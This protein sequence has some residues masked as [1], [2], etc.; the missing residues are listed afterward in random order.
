MFHFGFGIYRAFGG[1]R[2][3]A[4]AGLVAALLLTLPVPSTKAHEG[5]D[6]GPSEAVAGQLAPRISARSETFEL[7]GI[8]RGERLVIY[9]DR[10]AIE[11]AGHHRRHRGDDRRRGRCG[12]RRVGRRGHLRADVAAIP[13]RGTDRAGV[14]DHRR[15]RRRFARWHA[16]RA[17]G[18]HGVGAGRVHDRRAAQ[19]AGVAGLA[20]MAD[21]AARDRDDRRSSC[22]AL[23]SCCGA[24]SCRRRRWR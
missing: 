20:A 24:I 18:R 19:L 14:L 17:V 11:R 9:L 6:H 23:T 22:T 2:P 12:E 4:I 1:S 21:G 15:G 16:H 3:G 10:F 13:D 5:H 7:V 8:L